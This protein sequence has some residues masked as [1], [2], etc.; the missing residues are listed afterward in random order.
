MTLCLCLL[1]MAGPCTAQYNDSL[2]HM[3]RFY[4]DDDFMNIYFQGTDDAYT[5]GTRIDYF[6]KPARRSHSFTDRWMPRAGDG[7]IDVYG[8]GA[9]QIMYTPD[10]ITDPGYQPD[11]YPWSGALFATH[12]C[13]SYNPEK[14]YDLQTQLILGVIGPAALARQTQ[15]LVHHVENY[16]KP[17]GWG[18]QFDNDLLI[19]INF[20]AEKQL[21][22]IASVV[23]VVGG[24]Q[25]YAGTMQNGASLYSLIMIGKMN[26]YFKGLF[27]QYAGAGKK[28]GRQNCQLYFFVK[29]E[30]QFY[31]SNA[32]LQG[33]PFT[34]NPNLHSS[35][36]SSWN[37]NPN[38]TRDTA[39]HMRPQPY[40]S[41]QPWVP[42]FTY[43]V[44]ASCG[45]WG[46]SFSQIVSA[47]TLRGLYC[48]NYG[49][50]SLFYSW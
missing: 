22:A 38:F 5:N 42:T 45:H 13:Y 37:G 46:I 41:L 1:G 15:T 14:K 16:Y 11:D 31:L 36:D 24:A 27:S 20:M 17:L 48:H 25:L 18:H 32:M 43:G 35:K 30:V 49:N 28:N 50:L 33:G 44:S 10:N 23:N 4:E 39:A 2:S 9:M 3:I 34:T 26:P 29:P 21:A 40:R 7:S 19:N 6:Y 8:W 12:T 47:A